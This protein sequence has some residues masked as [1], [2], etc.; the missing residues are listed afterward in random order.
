MRSPKSTDVDAYIANHP[1]TVRRR[2]TEMRA[3]VRAAAPGATES[4]SYRIPAYKLNGVLV[5]FAAHSAHIGFY[6]LT[7][8]IREELGQV[9]AP[10]TTKVAKSTARFPLDRPIPRAL[11]T[12]MV[13]IR[14]R[15]NEERDRRRAKP[16]R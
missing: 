6:P 14:L 4:I 12:R 1:P 9:L 13:R 2:L 7:K 10:Y 16:R 5:Y 11:V 3:F 15:E 8:R